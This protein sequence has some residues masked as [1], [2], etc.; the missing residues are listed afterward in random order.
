MDRRAKSLF[1]AGKYEEAIEL[2]GQ[3]YADTG[4]PVYLRNV[5]RCYQRLRLPEKAIAS[6][7]E[8]LLR[9]KDVSAAE[10][11]EV[12]GFIR[13]MED[14]KRQQAA[15][16]AAAPVP[17]PTPVPQP[18]PA[19]AE[20]APAPA[21]PLPADT[22]PPPAPPTPAPAVVASAPADSSTR[23]STGRLVSYGLG[24]AAVAAAAAGGVFLGLS[25]SAFNKAKENPYCGSTLDCAASAST[26][27]QRNT[28]A[29]VLFAGAAVLGAA[30]V[31]VFMVTPGGEDVALA[32][33]GTF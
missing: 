23:G 12:R 28:V 17:Q 22:A 18:P 5:G 19:P 1:A 31:V 2:L 7:E 30:G 9:G 11:D 14:L 6:F 24:G 20:S 13:E 26:V 21:Q 25:W 3:L 15:P 32:W 8:Y 4:N 29:K 33:R 16:A 10:R 27:R